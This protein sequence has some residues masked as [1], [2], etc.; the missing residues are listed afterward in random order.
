MNLEELKKSWNTLDQQLQKE[1]IANGKQI[2]ELIEGCKS[3]TKRSISR[4]LGLQRISMVTGGIVLL[5][6]GVAL[7][8]M[9]V[10]LDDSDMRARI[11]L[12]LLF[13]GVS[14]VI[15]IWWDWKTYRWN[16]Q[17]H[18]DEMSVAEVSRRMTTFRQW[19]RNEIIALCIWVVVFNAF[20][21]WVMGYHLK[22]IG[23]QVVIISAFTAIDILIICILY[24]KGIYQ[25][26][27]NIKKNIEELKD[28][29]TE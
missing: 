19:T 12:F 13:I 18:I 20:N 14:I 25:H 8:V 15:G 27:D 22:S 16:K 24:K 9:P 21:Y 11:S 6:L 17:T 28:R 3:G 26:L 5:L 10:V 7:I 29:C 23:T 2:K 1:Q 4:I